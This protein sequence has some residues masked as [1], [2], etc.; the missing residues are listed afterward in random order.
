[1][2][3]M[4]RPHPNPF[5]ASFGV[6]SAITYVGRQRE[7]T[8][9]L[10]GLAEYPGSTQRAITIA[11]PRGVGKTSL[12]TVMMDHA[13]Q[14]GWI[15]TS[16]T[17]GPGVAERILDKAALQAETL[18]EPE[19]RRR[20]T[21]ISLAGFSLQSQTI[22]KDTPSWWRR[23]NSLLDVLEAH[24]SGL[25]IAIDEIHRNETELRPL[26][27]Q[28]Q[29][30][31]ND[32]RNIAI[33]MAGLPDAVDS[34]LSEYALTFVQRAWRQ[35]LGAVNL[36]LIEQAY[37]NAISQSGKHISADVA[38]Y[39][40][41]QSEGFPYLYQLIGYF[42]WRAAEASAEITLPDIKA[43]IPL[44]QATAGQNL[45]GLEVGAL[46]PRERQFLDALADTS[47]TATIKDIAA[48]LGITENNAYYYRNRLA[49]R[50]LVQP[51]APGGMRFTSL[52]LRDYLRNQV[53]N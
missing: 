52:A 11:G 18:L 37:I 40:A 9:F 31:V 33:V 44:A 2:P 38:R 35:T 15:T 1:M 12:L 46:S 13:K 50:G 7:L 20:L 51:I 25:V 34:V 42:A 26:F 30:L 43:A 22:P 24:D 10:Q 6:P 19:P 39:A 47:G 41:Q 16:V 17:A 28:Y 29:E 27:Q 49:A 21:G 45:Y 4:P 23:V 53:Q 8:E 5:T 14:E 32:R 48:K 36:D 3:P